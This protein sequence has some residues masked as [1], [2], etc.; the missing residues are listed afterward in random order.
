MSSNLLCSSV[1]QTMRDSG[2]PR[3]CR[4]SH[5][6]AWRGCKAG[7]ALE[8]DCCATGVAA[9]C[10]CTL[11]WGIDGIAVPCGICRLSA[12]FTQ[13][14]NNIHFSRLPSSLLWGWTLALCGHH[15]LQDGRIA[16]HAQR[17][18]SICLCGAPTC[19]LLHAIRECP[20]FDTRRHTWVERLS[21]R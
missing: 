13:G 11:S 9:T 2:I 14:G 7:C 5:P 4:L 12:A 21:L 1:S 10:S 17:D 19:T 20:L 3:S 16:R 6:F 18:A 15:P 8:S